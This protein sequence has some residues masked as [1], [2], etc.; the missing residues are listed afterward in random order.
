MAAIE[1]ADV[2]GAVVV[3]AIDLA[4]GCCTADADAVVVAVDEGKDDIQD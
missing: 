2:V 3:V 1:A 4:E